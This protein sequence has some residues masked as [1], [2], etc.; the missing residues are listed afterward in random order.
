[1]ACLTTQ[2]SNPETGIQN[3]PS[4]FLFSF[5]GKILLVQGGISNPL[6]IYFSSLILLLFEEETPILENVFSCLMD[7]EMSC[8]QDYCEMIFVFF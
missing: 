5:Q 3:Y 7:V 8:N 1:M 2:K 6:K 4:F